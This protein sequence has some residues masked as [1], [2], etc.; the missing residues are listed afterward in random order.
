[1]FP[2]DSLISMDIF[3]QVANLDDLD[4]P[5]LQF[6]TMLTGIPDLINLALP[7]TRDLISW[8]ERENR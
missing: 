3:L 5:H 8:S 6:D 2:T 7:A 4:D 1:M